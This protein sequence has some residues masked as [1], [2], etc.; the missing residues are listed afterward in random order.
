MQSNTTYPDEL[1]DSP[2]L[3]PGTARAAF[4]AAF[5]ERIRQCHSLAETRRLAVASR[6]AHARGELLPEDLATLLWIVGMVRESILWLRT[7]AR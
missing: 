6:A 4:R 2:P 3:V 7:H 5:A 1:P